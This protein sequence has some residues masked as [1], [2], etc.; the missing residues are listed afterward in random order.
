MSQIYY[1]SPNFQIDESFLN[2][3]RIKIYDSKL[4]TLKGYSMTQK[5]GVNDVNLGESFLKEDFNNFTEG[6][7]YLIDEEDLPRI[8]KFEK[9]PSTR[10]KVS[11]NVSFRGDKHDIP[12]KEAITYIGKYDINDSKA[13]TNWTPQK[14]MSRMKSENKILKLTPGSNS[15]KFMMTFEQYKDK[16]K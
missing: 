3:N 9:F 1:F 2:K 11:V 15:D 7:C 16:I 4:A 13:L 6:V 8:D 14:G 12:M 10:D 5:R